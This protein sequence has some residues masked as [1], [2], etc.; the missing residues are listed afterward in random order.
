MQS[1]VSRVFHVMLDGLRKRMESCVEREQTDASMCVLG[2]VGRSASC[3]MPFSQS[4]CCLVLVL[5]GPLHSL[6]EQNCDFTSAVMLE[7]K[8]YQI[9]C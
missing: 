8:D 7:H 6:Y 5:I 3:T 1:S 2:R 9:I 4:S